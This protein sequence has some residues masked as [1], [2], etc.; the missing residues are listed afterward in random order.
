ML[1]EYLYNSISLKNDMLCLSLINC[2]P[3]FSQVISGTIFS[4]FFFLFDSYSET[5][6][7]SEDE[8]K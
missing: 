6:A 7:A 1:N 3:N 5:G 4:L 8:K 2:I